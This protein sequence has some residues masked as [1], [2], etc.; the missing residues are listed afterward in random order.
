MNLNEARN[1]SE[2][3]GKSWW[4]FVTVRPLPESVV[5][6]KNAA[7]VPSVSTGLTRFTKWKM[8]RNSLFDFLP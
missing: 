4:A 5:S 3:L 2:E 1:L 7:K 8:G 6:P